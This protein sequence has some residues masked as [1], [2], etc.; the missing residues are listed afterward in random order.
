MAFTNKKIIAGNWKMNGL[1]RDSWQLINDLLSKYETPDEKHNFEMIV[2][3][4]STLLS[5]VVSMTEGSPIRVG[6]QNCS[7]KLNGAY[8]GEISPVMIKDIGANFVILGHSERRSYFK[9]SNTDVAS[10]AELAIE[11]GLTPI[12]CIGETLEQKENGSALAVIEDQFM[13]SI[14]S[15]ATTEN[16]IVAYEPV[17]AIGTGRSATTQDIID[18]ITKIREVSEKKFGLRDVSVLYG[19]SVKSSNADEIFAISD[20]DGVLVGGASLKAD[21]FWK[22]AE[23]SE[24]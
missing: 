19:G 13:N 24:K 7:D 21:E 20:V 9:E 3:P 11:Q 15:N 10:K 4:P 17:W 12:I 2:C 18:V 6:A 5:E 14:P 23:A 1:K 8:T 16:V 22:I